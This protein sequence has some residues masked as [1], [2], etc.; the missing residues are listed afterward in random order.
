LHTARIISGAAI[1]W[2]I[3][4]LFACSAC[5]HEEVSILPAIGFASGPDA[6]TSAEDDAAAGDAEAKADA[7]SPSGETAVDAALGGVTHTLDRAQ[8]GTETDGAGKP[9]AHVEAH[10]G[11]DPACPSSDPDA[12]AGAQPQYTLVVANVP[13][14]SA[15]ETFTK[16]GDGVTAAYFDFVGDQLDTKP[17]TQAS[18]VKVTIVATSATTFEFDVEATFD[19]GTA[20]GRITASFCDSLSLSL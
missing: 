6:S 1:A 16:A 10:L 15:G 4:A 19:E 11:G 14:G 17:L 20:K 2:V 7:P 12:A 3:A 8:F 5:S 9:R 13:R 18:A